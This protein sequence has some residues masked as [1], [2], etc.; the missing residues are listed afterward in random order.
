MPAEQRAR[1]RF[2]YEKYRGKNGIER[3]IDD[4]ESHVYFPRELQLIFM[5]AGFEIENIYG[6]YARRQL[7]SV[8]RQMS[9]VG[10][11]PTGS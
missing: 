2:L 4:F 11:K 9:M 7:R 10:R 8:S 1:I 3:Y 6:D 5:N